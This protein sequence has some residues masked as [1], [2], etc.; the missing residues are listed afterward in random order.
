MKMWEELVRVLPPYSFWKSPAYLGDWLLLSSVL[1]DTPPFP[2]YVFFFDVP[3]SPPIN[4]D[5]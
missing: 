4:E 3:V 5:P 1:G 2:H